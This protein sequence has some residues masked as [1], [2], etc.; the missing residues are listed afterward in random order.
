MSQ[1]CKELL[2]GCGNRRHKDMGS[3]DSQE[4]FNLVTLDM[5]P[6][7]HPDYIHNLNDM[8]YPF[9][10]NCFTEIHAYD[11]LEHCGSQGDYKFFFN[12]FSEFWRILKPFGMMF[13]TVPKWDGMW[14]W[15]DPGHTRVLA[16]GCFY[17][18]CQTE[19]LQ[20][21][22]TKMTDYRDIYHAD[23]NVIKI[24]EREELQVA[25]YLQAIKE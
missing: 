16:P 14:A 11:V 7:C 18:L 25:A 23:F 15:G 21:G 12:Q 19:Y 24:E 9:P 17:Y 5:D 4:F 10:D 6:N 20:I 8:P 3:L 13:I 22:T 1:E 2:I